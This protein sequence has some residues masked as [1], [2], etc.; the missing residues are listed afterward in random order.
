M[1]VQVHIKASDDRQSFD[2]YLRR[3]P[4]IPRRLDKLI[5]TLHLRSVTEGVYIEPHGFQA[6]TGGNGLASKQ[7][8]PN[9][10]RNGIDAAPTNERALKNC[11]DTSREGEGYKGCLLVN[12]IIK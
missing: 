6:H 7:H 10:L 8:K 4:L 1:N 11:L 9:A 3:C 2:P 12:T 5:L